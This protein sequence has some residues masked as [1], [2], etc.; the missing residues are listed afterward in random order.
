MEVNIFC[1]DCLKTMDRFIK[2]NKRVN[3]ILTSPPYNIRRNVKSERARK[4]FECFYDE[5]NDNMSDDKYNNFI[6]DIFD[7]FDKI[8]ERNGVVLWNCNYGNENFNQPWQSLSYIF[9]LTEF[10]I[11]EV[12]YWKKKF[13]IPNNVSSNKLTRI[14]EP[15][16]VFARKDDFKTYQANKKV[17]SINK[18]TKQKFYKNYY[19]FIE[20]PNNDGACKLN[21]AT[22]SSELVRQ[23][24]NLYSKD[25]DI[26][27]DPFMGT[28]TTAVGAF[29]SEYLIKEVIGSEISKKQVDFSIDRI[30]KL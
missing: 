11:V 26:I 13:A 3:V 10:R 12:I 19:N 25:G 4:N 2:R 28:G 6:K 15:I 18:K 8:L 1:E 23:L 22:F 14:I 5:Y 7:K 17:S 20:A 21:K 16:F 29:L 9:L 24:L 27:Y 30:S